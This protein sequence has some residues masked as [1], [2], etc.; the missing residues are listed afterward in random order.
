[1]SPTQGIRPRVPLRHEGRSAIGIYVDLS[2]DYAR[3]KAREIAALAHRAGFTT[4]VDERQA[5][6]L[7]FGP[8]SVGLD[9]AALLVTIGG[10][11]TVLR[12]ARLAAPRHI[13][14]FGINAGRLG[15]LTEIDV[16]SDLGE[17][18]TIFDQGFCEERRLA[19]EAQV[20]E[21]T[22]FAL[23]DV[24]V[25]KHDAA[26]VVPFK[27]ALDRD[28]AAH[29][30]CDGLVVCTPTGSTAYFLSA[31]GPIIAPNVDAIGIAPLLPHTLF[32]RPLI[33]SADTMISICAESA[34]VP[35]I[36][37]SDGE[38]VAELP[39]GSKVHIARSHVP[40]RFARAT[41]LP[42]F[43]RLER[44]F[45]WGKSLRETVR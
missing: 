10:D 43:T 1:M 18:Q 9:G 26:R 41:P 23:N 31:G 44:K 14:I 2:R 15:F 11:G 30:P 22:Y 29:I 13:P 37:E 34:A 12:A 8:D 20:G 32:S 19:L 21:R 27:L 24:V 4:A 40:V 16:G 6:G 42:F 17:L 45:S 5:E 38:F 28:E 25:R 33:V 36:L 7:D 3:A 35:S 39:P